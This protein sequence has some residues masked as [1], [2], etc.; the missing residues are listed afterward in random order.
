[1]TP[2]IATNFFELLIIAVFTVCSP[3]IHL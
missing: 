2:Q 1:V 3:S